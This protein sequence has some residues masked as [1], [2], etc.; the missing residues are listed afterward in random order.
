MSKIESG[1]L[2][3]AHTPFSLADLL[4]EL[5]AMMQPEA[6]KKGHLLEF[7]TFGVAHET[8]LGDQQKLEQV[9]MNLLSNAL[10]Y[11]S[12]GGHIVFELH[13]KPAQTPGEALYVFSCTDNGYGMKPEFL[14]KV[15]TPFA[16]A[17]DELVRAIQGTGLGMAISYNIATAM[18]G[19][20]TVESEY[21]RGSVFTLTLPLACTE[22]QPQPRELLRGR[23]VLILPGDAS[24]ELD[25]V[26]TL[27]ATGMTAALTHSIDEAKALAAR[28]ADANEPFTFLLIPLFSTR[29]ETD[30]NGIQAAAA[31]HRDLGPRCPKILLAHHENE[32]YEESAEEAGVAAF[33]LQPFFR[34]RLW[35]SL[36]RGLGEKGP[37]PV[38]ALPTLGSFPGKRILLAE[39]NALNREIAVELLSSTMAAVETAV[40][41]R[42]ALD[43]MEASPENYFDLILLDIQMPVMDGYETARAIR[44]LSREDAKTVPIVA[45]TANA[46]PEDIQKALDSGM[47][48]H[49]SKPVGLPRLLETLTRYL[50]Q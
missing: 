12:E 48:D 43:R 45:M 17:D 39:D 2:R 47:N 41:G 18:G 40:D 27:S 15:F 3:L 35:A 33:V 49:L 46:F 20:L 38:A 36:A 44:A 19:E 1:E 25:L 24:M 31:L 6:E 23:S 34:S 26:P 9:L 42:R 21:G 13:E 8:V 14:S 4:L 28:Q 10:K 29:F 11:T 32:I 37:A 30:F 5:S 22:D 16:R 7:C 50:G